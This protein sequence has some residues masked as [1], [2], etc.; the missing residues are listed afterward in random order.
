MPVTPGTGETEAGEPPVWGQPR[1]Q[2]EVKANKD[3]TV[4]LCLKKFLFNQLQQKCY[5]NAIKLQKTW[6][7]QI[8]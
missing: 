8:L 5:E 3:Y 7:I 4:K 2:S 6:S 1:P